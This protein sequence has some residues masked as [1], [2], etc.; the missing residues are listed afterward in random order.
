MEFSWSVPERIEGK[1]EAVMIAFKARA[2]E[3]RPFSSIMSVSA[4]GLRLEGGGS[5]VANIELRAGQSATERRVFTLDTPSALKSAMITVNLN[6]DISFRYR[7]GPER[8][9]S[10]R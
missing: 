8:Y 2:G 7:Y 9:P 6:R 5:H 10:D 1:G 3:A 4:P